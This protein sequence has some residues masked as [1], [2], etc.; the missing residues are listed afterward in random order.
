MSSKTSAPRS[1][2]PPRRRL[3]RRRRRE[4]HLD[5]HISDR[6]DLL[7]RYLQRTSK[8]DKQD[9][10]YLQTQQAIDD[11]LDNIHSF[12]II[13]EAE[14][15]PLWRLAQTGRVVQQVESFHRKLDAITARCGLA[16][17]A[18]GGAGP[19]LPRWQSRWRRMRSERLVFFRT[20][21]EEQEVVAVSNSRVREYADQIELLTLLKHDAQ[22]FDTLLTADESELLERTFAFVV[23]CCGTNTSVDAQMSLMSV[24]EWFVAPYERTKQQFKWQRAA[25]T[26]HKAPRG[27]TSHECLALASTWSRMQH[28]HIMKLFGA[29]HVSRKRFF[30][31]AEGTPLTRC[32][33]DDGFPLWRALHEAALALRYLHDRRV[34]LDSLSCTDLVLFRS[35]DRDTVMVAGFNLRQMKSSLES[36][37][38]FESKKTRKEE[39]DDPLLEDDE[40]DAGYD[41]VDVIRQGKTS[42][43]DSCAAGR[44]KYWKAPELLSGSSSGPTEAS[45]IYALGM[46]VVEAFS[47]GGIWDNN[48]DP[49]D[50]DMN[51][52]MPQRPSALS[53]AEQW[54]VVE[55]MCSRDPKNRPSLTEVLASF[56]IFAE[57]EQKDNIDFSS[58]KRRKKSRNPSLRQIQPR[59]TSAS[60]ACALSEVQ[61]WCDEASE[62][63][64]L[65]YQLYERMDD[66]AARLEVMGANRI[67]RHLPT[68]ASLI[69]RF[70]DMLQR[71]VNENPLLR[72]AATRQVIE[73]NLAL[74]GELDVLMDRLRIKRSGAS[75]HSWSSQ[76]AS[77]REQLWKCVRLSLAKDSQTLS[78]ELDGEQEL[79]L[80]GALLAFEVKKRNASYSTRDLEL[81]QTT[82]IKLE[83]TYQVM[84]PGATLGFRTT[85]SKTMLAL[86]PWFVPPYEVIF[87]ELDAFSRGAFGSV[88]CGQWRSVDVVVKKIPTP[89][90]HGVVIPLRSQ[91]GAKSNAMEPTEETYRQFLNDMSTWSTL[92]H[93]HVLKLFG[94]CHVGPRQFFLCEYAAHGSIDSYVSSQPTEE[95]SVCARRVLREAA[96]GLLYLHEHNVVHADLKCSNILVDASGTVKHTDFVLSALKN[97]RQQDATTM[98]NDNVVGGGLRWLAPE[99]LS[100]EAATTASNVFSFAMCAIEIISGEIPWGCEMTDAAIRAEVRKGLLPPRPTNGYSDSEW[101]LIQRMCCHDPEER[102][103]MSDVV[104]LLWIP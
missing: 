65:N 16:V 27:M 96:L 37:A 79:A 6:L 101:N 29:C 18:P 31:V 42:R 59:A 74:H 32:L 87:N 58:T 62:S 73:T 10:L 66:L 44:K 39:Q 33:G 24:P 78:S 40:S 34:G 71:H 103:A 100:G 13:Y 85:E 52:R 48:A 11:L 94:A 9:A 35:G 8:F 19:S 55:R 28:P 84:T 56:Q 86:P 3:H 21:L 98:D 70:R 45:D 63:S 67:A 61:A 90:R 57:D 53:N 12:F 104:K 41:D 75:I 23:S 80:L 92:E 14:K 91:R 36:S 4:P 51:G 49:E 17:V 89:G 2:Q 95:R 1:V 64:A 72:L 102:I 68:L 99:C 88:H 69:L 20:Y 50:M 93:T 60:I 22:K 83:E 82:L 38:V 7:A 26:V 43:A 15:R 46:C 81:L 30:V 25:V 54:A 47:G 77:Y 76:Q 97:R 5:H